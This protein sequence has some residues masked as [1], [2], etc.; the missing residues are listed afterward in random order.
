MYERKKEFQHSLIFAQVR[1]WDCA[2]DAGQAI[3]GA[4]HPERTILIGPVG[5]RIYLQLLRRGQYIG[6]TWAGAGVGHGGE[7]KPAGEHRDQLPGRRHLAAI[8]SSEILHAANRGEHITVIFINNAIYSMTGG[9]SAPTTLIG[10]KST[11]T[12]LGRS[13]AMKDTRCTYANCWPRSKLR[14]HR[15]GWT[16]ATTNRLRRP[17]APSGSH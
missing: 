12:P 5:S 15:A 14:L 17:R 3:R 4:G 16:G 13:A 7:T 11:T 6:S 2:Q 1:A 10:Q 9:Q 8:G